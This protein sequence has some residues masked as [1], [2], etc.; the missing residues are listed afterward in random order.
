[1]PANESGFDQLR[2]IKAQPDI[3]AT[4]AGILGKT[5]AAVR[6]KLGGLD[7][8]DGRVHQLA[9]LLALLVADGG[10]QVLDFDQALAH[11]HHLGHIV[12][13]GDPGTAKQ[14]RVERQEALRLYRIAAGGALPL[15]QTGP[16]VEPADGIHT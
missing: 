2:L 14:L 3:G 7:L 5:D 11:E 10:L 9:E 15:Q 4:A 16:A 1:W 6:Q 12:D 13:S 8:S